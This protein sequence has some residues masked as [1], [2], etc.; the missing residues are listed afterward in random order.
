M[1]FSLASCAPAVQGG[2]PA[3]PSG[4]RQAD[5]RVGLSAGWLD[6]GEAA[7]NV[8]L[9]AN[10]NRPE[11]F[12]NPANPVDGDFSNTDLAFSGNHVF[13]GNYHGFTVYDISD[14][15]SPRLRTSVVCPGG[16][17]DISVHDNLLFLS[18]EQTRGRV[19]CG[20][21]GVADTVSAERFRG[22]RIFDIS[23]LDNPR[24]VAAVQTCR[25][26]HTH[27]L[28]SDPRD[29]ANLYVYV[30]GTSVARPAQELAG[31][32][33][34]RSPDDP[35]T[36]YWSIA[37]IQVPLAAP[38]QARVVSEPRVFADAQT[39]SIAGLWQGG[40]HGPGTQRTS[41]TNQCHDIT[42]Y[43]EIGLAAGACSGN[44]ILFDISNPANPVRIHEVEDPNF[45]Y[46]HSAT[47]SND[48]STVIFTDEWGGGRGARCQATDAEEWGANAIFNIVDRKMQFASYYKLPAAQTATENCV[49]HNGSLVPVPGR[50]IKAQAW[51]QGGLSVFDFTDAANPVEIAFF[52]RGPVSATELTTGGYWSTYWYNGNIYGSEIARGLDVFQLTPSEHLSQN[53]IEAARL[54]QFEQF[55]PQNQPMIVWPASFA[56]S[57][58]YLDQLGRNNGLPQARLTG[59]RGE[60]D[61]AERMNGAQRSAA[62]TQLAT[63]LDADAS[64]AGDPDRVRALAASIRKLADA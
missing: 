55:N 18:V 15:R 17:G 8:E 29:A 42:A 10:R 25:G 35:N 41:Q 60:L 37:V 52:D 40:D 22:V 63:Q 44:G 11:G 61:R 64:G 24:Q 54:V 28:V 48:G 51:Y 6:A 7:S 47:F 56:V 49:A 39:G 33:D 19:D 5:P 30:S 4:D 43:P 3:G 9:L 13:V 21:Q 26:S 58:A 34:V 59:V 31:C 62:L 45:A 16:Q 27:T 53:E 50:D 12:F 38:Q 57:R 36:S 14:P 46:W 2:V 23:N 32:V 20:V 1:F